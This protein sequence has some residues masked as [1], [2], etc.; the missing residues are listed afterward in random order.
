MYLARACA[1]PLAAAGGA[2]VL[3][4]SAAAVE[5]SKTNSVYAVVKGATRGFARGLAAEWGPSGVRVNTVVPLAISPTVERGFAAD[6]ALAERMAA[7]TSLKRVGD[8]V[9]DIGPAVALLISDHARFVTGQTIAI[10]GGRL[11]PM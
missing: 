1:Q 7:L 8:A 5:G 4:S 10:D 11:V 9:D 3:M 6:P 2:M